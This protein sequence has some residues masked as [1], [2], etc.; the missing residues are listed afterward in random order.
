M[1]LFIYLNYRTDRVREFEKRLPSV[2]KSLK[3]QELKDQFENLIDEKAIEVDK[4]LESIL[5]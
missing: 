3:L 4:R 5:K 1:Y 2:K